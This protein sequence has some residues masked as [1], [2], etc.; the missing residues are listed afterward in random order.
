MSKLWLPASKECIILLN[1]WELHT[2][3]GA[4]FKFAA[5]ADIY[6]SK[7]KSYKI[8]AG[9]IVQFNSLY[10][11]GSDT[12]SI[13]LRGGMFKKMVSCLEV[14]AKDINGIEYE[15]YDLQIT[16]KTASQL[17]FTWD[18]QYDKGQKLHEN[19]V[20]DKFEQL[21]NSTISWIYRKNGCGE[22]KKDDWRRPTFIIKTKVWASY[23]LET[24]KN[25]TGLGKSEIPI[26][27]VTESRFLLFHANYEG[28]KTHEDGILTQIGEFKSKEQVRKAANKYLEEN[29]KTK[30]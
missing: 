18:D 21:E 13:N 4:R 12:M 11:F 15:P 7:N 17:K 20:P 25:R 6:D 5:Y 30:N 28:K 16:P 10:K 3:W 2:S 23:Y 27:T 24:E 1:D 26:I 22:L 29:E 14:T 9:T 19:Y 8:P